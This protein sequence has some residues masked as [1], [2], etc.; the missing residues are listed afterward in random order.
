M[1]SVYSEVDPV[2]NLGNNVPV[3][4]FKAM[5]DLVEFRHLRYIVALAEAGNFTRA[6]EQLFL[7]QPSL[8]SMQL[9]VV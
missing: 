1:P 7:S 5:S 4:E 2:P 8:K 9:E 6:A 3:E